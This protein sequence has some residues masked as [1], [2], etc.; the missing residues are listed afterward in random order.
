MQ[1]LGKDWGGYYLRC[2]NTWNGMQDV[3]KK[4]FEDLPTLQ[5]QLTRIPIPERPD[6][7]ACIGQDVSGIARESVVGYLKVHK[8]GLIRD[9]VVDVEFQMGKDDPRFQD[10]LQALADRIETRP[11]SMFVLS[12]DQKLQARIFYRAFTEADLHSL[13]WRA[14]S[15]GEKDPS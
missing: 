15:A 11:Q 4:N 12:R 10:W 2:L 7:G 1:G 13:C 3:I 6:P 8:A 14:M 5:R 9:R